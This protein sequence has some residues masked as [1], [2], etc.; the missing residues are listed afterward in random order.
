MRSLFDAGATIQFFDPQCYSDPLWHL[1]AALERAFGS[2]V[3]VLYI[4]RIMR[5][6][7]YAYMYSC[8]WMCQASRCD[9]CVQCI[10]NKFKHVCLWMFLCGV[11]HTPSPAPDHDSSTEHP[12]RTHTHTSQTVTCILRTLTHTRAHTHTSRIHTSLTHNLS[13]THTHTHA[14][15]PQLHSYALS[16]T[17]QVRACI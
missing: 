6:I 3:G 13:H 1:Q 5:I 2:L 15:I 9:V 8:M 7:V 10:M 12:P 17:P 14:H 11:K 4:H 16:H